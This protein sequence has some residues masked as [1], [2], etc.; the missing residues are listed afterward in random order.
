M[1]IKFYLFL[2]GFLFIGFAFISLPLFTHLKNEVHQEIKL[3]IF[4]NKFKESELI[5]FS[6]KELANAKWLDSKEFILYDQLFD[7]VKV[8]ELSG[9]KIYFAYHD[10]KETKIVKIEKGIQQLNSI[11]H[12]EQNYRRPRNSNPQKFKNLGIEMV[13]KSQRYCDLPR[14]Q[15]RNLNFQTQSKVSDFIKRE[16]LPP[17]F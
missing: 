6:E 14:T 1:K 4:K 11:N 12:I 16:I 8:K 9:K 5:Q 15:P 13:N 10:R 2:S 3:K 17:R 7:V